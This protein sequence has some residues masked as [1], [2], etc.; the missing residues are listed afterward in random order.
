[1]SLEREPSIPTL[2]R[3]ARDADS[4]LLK[5]ILK[6]IINDGITPDVLN[7]TD[8]NGRTALSYICSTDLIQFLDLLLQLKGIDVNI[9]DNEGNT[10][11]H[12]AAQG[13]LSEIVNMLLTRC[14]SINIDAKNCWGFTPMMK[15]ALQGKTR[16]AKLLLFAGASPA[17]TDSGRGLNAAEWARFTE[18]D[19][20]AEMIEKCSKARNL[21]P[22]TVVA[23]KT[24]A[25]T[26]KNIN[27]IKRSSNSFLS[28]INKFLPLKNSIK[29][30]QN[31]PNSVNLKNNN[32]NISVCASGPNRETQID[33]TKNAN[34]PKLTIS[35]PRND[36]EFMKK[37]EKKQMLQQRYVTTPKRRVRNEIL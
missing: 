11:L 2:L 23:T 3:A 19:S 35:Q 26:P 1:M 9:G 33:L 13:G 4:Y 22:T 18:R 31:S 34:V 32:N 17:V 24:L 15:A 10:P 27:I 8:R 6:K 28:K 16:C 25:C 7:K 29:D 37:Y 14:R 5:I 20:C 30:K 12:Y 36:I 21:K